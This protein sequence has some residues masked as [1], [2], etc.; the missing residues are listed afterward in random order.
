MY[1]DGVKDLLYRANAYRHLMK[2]DE[3]QR[4]REAREKAGFPTPKAAS[5]HF[6]WNEHTYK[7]N[8]N[9]IR[10]ISKKEAPKYAKAFHVSAGWILFEDKEGGPSL[11]A[12]EHA[13]L[14]KFRSLMLEHQQAV[15][16]MC[17]SLMALPSPAQP[18]IPLA[19]RRRKA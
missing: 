14:L 10:G 17:D 3:H 2:R 12:D 19:P 4:L 6:G 11:S 5:D 1:R 15:H 8:E 18:A 16:A 7:S 13:V 9:G